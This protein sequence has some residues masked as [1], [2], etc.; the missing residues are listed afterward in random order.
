VRGNVKCTDGFVLFDLDNCNF[1]DG[2]D[3]KVQADDGRG[4]GMKMTWE[5]HLHL[6]KTEVDRVLRM[7]L[8]RGENLI[9]VTDYW[10]KLAT[11]TRVAG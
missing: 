5:A 1:T 9:M 2:R 7:L 8:D 3:G 10:L 6:V 4:E 11:I